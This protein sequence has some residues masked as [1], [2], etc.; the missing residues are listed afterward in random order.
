[1]IKQYSNVRVFGNNVYARYVENGERRQVKIP[2]NPTFYLKSNTQEKYHTLQGAPLRPITLG[3]IKESKEF[4]T[5]YS[6]IDNFEVYGMENIAY[7][8]LAKEYSDGMQW[9]KDNL[10]IA[11]FDIEVESTEGFPEPE[12]ASYPVVSIAIKF[13]DE[14]FVLGTKK[15]GIPKE[16]RDFKYL[17]FNDEYQLLKGFLE[18][19]DRYRPDIMTGWNISGFDIPYLV[20]RISNVLGEADVKLL[21]PWRMVHEKSEFDRKTGASSKTYDLVGIS[22]IDYMI[23]YKK[24]EHTERESYSLDNIAYVELDE[25]KVDYKEHESLQGLYENDYDKF[26]RYNIKDVLLVERLEKKKRIIELIMFLAYQARINLEDTFF[27]VRMWNVIAYNRLASKNVITAPKKKEEK[28]EK[29]KGAFVKEPETRLYGWLASFDLDSLYPHLM[30]QYNISP[31]TLVDLS[32]LPDEIRALASKV[33]NDKLLHEQLD[34]SI[35]KKY[36]LCVT[37][38]GQFFRTDKRG[39]MAEIMD[40]QYIKR[41]EYKREMLKFEQMA[42]NEKDPKKVMEYMNKASGLNLFQLGMKETLNSAYG[43]C[44]S[45]YFRFYDLRL[46]TAITLSGQLSIHWIEKHLNQFMDKTLGTE[47]ERYVCYIDTDS[48]YIHID[49]L[50]KK[51]FG[52]KEPTVDQIINFI[53]KACS[54]K[55]QDVIDASFQK[56]ADYVNAYEQKMSMK[57]EYIASK[58][59]WRAKKNYALNVWDAE[60]VRYSHP[61]IKAKGME[62][63]KSSTPEFCRNKLRDALDIIMNGDVS[64]LRSLVKETEAEFTNLSPEEAASPRS[65]KVFEKYRSGDG[66]KKSTP[67]GAKAAIIYNKLIDANKL[68]KKYQKIKEGDKIKFFYMKDANPIFENVLG[69]LTVLPREFGLEGYIDYKKQFE[70]TFLAPLESILKIINWELKPKSRLTKHMRS[71]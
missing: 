68:N 40:E 50:V 2:F 48:T 64:E 43:A 18:I 14:M 17:K 67:I 31:D 26:I 57:R 4:I 24:F 37:P 16:E 33:N 70:V 69:F 5:K 51:V 41:K 22:K 21:S 36:N 71:E 9:S 6:D 52:D 12:Y 55:I 46:A 45:E 58:G 35:L 66:Y 62:M 54:G 47:G 8:F 59:F 10:L 7:Q 49:P 27:Q 39:F 30:M 25:R 32:E 42:E 44:G 56:L 38:N 20:N 34:L 65:C 28:T 19:W 23:A 53:D 15:L 61:K 60:G 29:Y 3:S 63:V 1:M 11:N 13:N